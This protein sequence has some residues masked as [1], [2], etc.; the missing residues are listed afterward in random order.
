MEQTKKQPQT[1]IFFLL[2]AAALWSTAGV[3][4][5]FNPW[6]GTTIACLRGLLAAI[7][8]ILL[9]RTF[10]FKLNKPIILT[11]LCYFGETFL[12]MIANK[13]TSAGSAIVLQN[14]SPLYIIL[15]LY[16][17]FRQKPSRLDCVVG[18]MIFG[19]ILLSMA[20]TLFSGN[21]PGSN[22]LLG[23]VLA[24]ISGVFYAGI[25]F[26]SRLPGADPLQS[27][28]L[29]SSLYVFLLPF[30][31]SDSSFWANQSLPAWGSMLFM[32][33]VQTGL[34]WL[35]FTKG[36]K[37]TPSLQASFITMIEPV[38]NP[39]LALLFLG[40]AMGGLSVVGSA[41]VIVTVFLHNYLTARQT[42]DNAN[43]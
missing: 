13:L 18:V 17:F 3:L 40:E 19:G 22:P 35:M 2:C 12:F 43:A 1:G 39:I 37:K 28:I 38:L 24:L 30:V 32:G 34:A 20:D 42:R 11:A 21:L 8:Q 27:T 9:T 4:T 7:T 14:T 25:F 15:F 29:G 26:S 10:R 36:I 23:N 6:S 33:I 41:V 31:F 5:K 16:L